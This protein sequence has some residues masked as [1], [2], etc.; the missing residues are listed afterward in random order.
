MTDF[1]IHCLFTTILCAYYW[2]IFK[3]LNVNYC[4]CLLE[5]FYFLVHFYFHKIKH[6]FESHVALKQFLY[7]C[8][9]HLEHASCARSQSSAQRSMSQLLLPKEIFN[10]KSVMFVSSQYFCPFM[11]LEM[12]MHKCVN[13]HKNVWHT[14]IRS[15]PETV[16]KSGERMIPRKHKSQQNVMKI[17]DSV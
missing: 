5:E 14:R 8:V 10:K 11:D 6:E 1:A 16:N 17:A 12:T 4:I 3:S 15:Q 9:A 13:R 2:I 7:K